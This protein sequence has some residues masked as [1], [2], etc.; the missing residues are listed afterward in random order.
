MIKSEKLSALFAETVKTGSGVHRAQE[1]AFML[2]ES[3]SPAFVKFLSNC[4]KKGTIRRLTNGIFE[5]TITPPDA[6]TAI[7]QIIKKLRGHVLSYI[8]LESQLSFT[9]DISQL[10]MDRVTIM[11]K[12]RSGEFITPYGTIEFVHS[13]KPVN[14]IM[15]NLYF[16][17]EI[18]MYR[19]T[20]EQAKKDLKDC[21]RNLHMLEG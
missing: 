2:G 15:P 12:G 16:D 14:E 18:K 13:K 17:S 19:A 7:Y 21:N 4:T 6:S 8:S 10:I 9:G 11:T 1:L 20:V 3:Y 5:S